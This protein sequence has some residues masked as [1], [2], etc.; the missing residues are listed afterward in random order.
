MSDLILSKHAQLK[1]HE[2]RIDKDLLVKA[3][4]KPEF[5]FYD[6]FSKS[7]IAIGKVVI[8][9]NE[10]YLVIPFIKEG[11]STKV[12]TVYPCKE[13]QKEIDKKEGKRWIRVK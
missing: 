13:I 4:E 9:G 3:I 7:M 1:I 12:I 2:R 6:L 5:L 10:T 8:Q 11:A